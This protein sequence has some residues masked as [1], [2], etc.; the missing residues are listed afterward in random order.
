M[1]TWKGFKAFTVSQVVAENDYIYSFY[2]TSPE[3][4]LLPD[5]LPGQFIAIKVLNEDNTWSKPR[6]YTLS[7]PSNG[8]H[9]KI[10]VKRE[11]EGDVSKKLCDTVQ[12]GDTVQISAPAGKF[13]LTNTT[14]PI[15]LIGGGIGITPMLTMAY[16]AVALDVPVQ[17]IYSLPN[18]TYH[19]F[20]K[21][22][23]QLDTSH[24][25]LTVTTVYTRPLLSDEAMRKFDLKGRLSK[26]W[27]ENNV[28]VDSIFY[29]CGPVEFMRSI[30]HFLI[31]LGVNPE[32]I[33]YELF[34]PGQDIKN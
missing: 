1:S 29:F 23:E 14:N 28:N 15:V 26:E 25:N 5:Y 3:G 21:E 24:Q 32:N 17:L 18:S 4:E 16:K 12:A 33:N 31:E 30:Y 6:Q 34:A 20:E 13:V 19:A 10:S 7:S 9:Y 27:F 8:N 2:L 22:I 11:P